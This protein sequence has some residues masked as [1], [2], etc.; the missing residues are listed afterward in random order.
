MQILTRK[1][2]ILVIISDKSSPKRDRDE[3]KSTVQ[4][5]SEKELSA[6]AQKSLGLS[7]DSADTAI[8]YARSIVEEGNNVFSF[9]CPNISELYEKGQIDLFIIIY[10]AG[11]SV[12]WMVWT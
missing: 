4:S 11:R 9:H 6:F 2:N 3:F 1:T 7:F 10:G 8:D 5:L 12:N